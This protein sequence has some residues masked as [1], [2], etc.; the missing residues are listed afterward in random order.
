MQ[1]SQR[2][3]FYRDAGIVHVTPNVSEDLSPEAELADR[4]TVYT[5][6]RDVTK[7]SAY[8]DPF[9]IVLMPQGL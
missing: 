3:C 6:E 8:T 5:D 9:V 7:M 4:L 1:Q 2:T